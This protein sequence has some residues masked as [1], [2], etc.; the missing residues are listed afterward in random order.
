MSAL[1]KLVVFVPSEAEEA[2]RLALG[3]AGAG[4]IGDYDHCAFVTA[5]RGHYRPLEGSTPYRGQKGRIETAE[6]FR[7]EVLVRAEDVPTVLE[8][9]RDTHPYEEVAWDLY[10]LANDRFDERG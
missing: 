10:P 3:A 1:Y 9:M 6:E 4:R 7:V 2:V 8:A 5:G